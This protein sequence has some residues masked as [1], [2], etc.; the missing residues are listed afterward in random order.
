MLGGLSPLAVAALVAL[1]VVQLSLQIFALVDLSRRTAVTGGRK[2]I[3]VVVIIAGSL[4]GAILYLA[5]GRLPND[6]L[7]ST[8]EVG[9][10]DESATRRALDKLYGP[11][12][13][14]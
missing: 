12:E 8:N 4:L 3:W 13:R 11:D 7:S 1:V 10:G 9:V 6:A 5:L 2:W 14:P